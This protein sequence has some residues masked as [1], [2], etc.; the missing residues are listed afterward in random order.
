MTVFVC[1]DSF[2]KSDPEY[3]PCWIDLLAQKISV[4]NLSKVCASNLQIALQVQQALDQAAE[5]VIYLA[6]SSVRQDVVL[7]Q[8]KSKRQLL[9][10]YID[11]TTPDF[12]KDLV[13]YSWASLDET[14]LFDPDQ[15]NLLRRYH[16]EF[17]DLDL[18]IYNN[19]LIIEATLHKL[20]NSGV[21]FL[22]DQGGFEHPGFGSSN[23]YFEEFDAWRSELNLWNYIAGQPIKHRPYYH[24]VDPT[25]HV[26]IANY[27]FNAIK[28][29]S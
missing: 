23:K 18:A 16:S 22:F 7:N 21:P 26:N 3:G 15:L 11:I 8:N 19:Q 5:F 24:I 29:H 2:A 12:S 27:Y 4:V 1:G 25:T 14:T 28:K 17:S 9:D 13:S 6:T 10:R 20:R